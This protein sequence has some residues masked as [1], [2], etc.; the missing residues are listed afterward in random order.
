MDDALG[1]AA[2]GRG[3]TSPN[4]MVGAVVVTPSG[5]VVGRGFHEQAGAPHAEAH[6]LDR[7]G[8]LAA[9]STLYC[10]LEPCNHIGRTGPCTA[11][12]IDA[13]VARVVVGVVDPDPRVSG[14][15]IERLRGHGIAVDVG[16][17]RRAAARLNEAFITRVT[18]GRPFVAMK[19]A[20]SRDG[21]IAAG[22]GVR[23]TLTSGPM[24]R[25][26]QGWRSEVDAIG[27]GS[28]TM[29][30]DDP[31]LTVR[32]VSRGAPLTRV[33]F[34]RRLRTPTTARMFTTLAT[35][36]IVVLTTTTSTREKNATAESL[37][38]RGARVEVVT[39]ETIDVALARLAELGINSLLLEGGARVHRAAWRAGVVDKVLRI[40]T[41]SVLGAE[42]VGWIDDELS[43]DGLRDRRDVVYGPD[44]LTEGYVQRVD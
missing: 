6:A 2:R 29:I 27:V 30:V 9:G 7:A 25:V 22:P 3:R 40:A 34:D 36:P 5:Q 24:N 28:T 39:G 13:G 21:R 41:P 16:V 8:A 20:V 42:G 14:A 1:L 4:P 23:T 15:G 31:L 32:G 33:I 19:V 38:Q 35:G 43:V 10:N 18:L 44:V 12:I 26:A 17:R 37:R 11:R